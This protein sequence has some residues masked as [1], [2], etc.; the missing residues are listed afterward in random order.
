MGLDFLGSAYRGTYANE[1]GEV[2]LFILE[3][4]TSDDIQK[5]IT[6]YLDFAGEETENGPEE[7]A[8]TIEDPFNG[9]IHLHWTGNY[10][11]GF[12]GDDMAELRSGL[13]SQMKE[14]LNL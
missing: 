13:L 7:G 4:E 10:I 14:N 2:T 11:V 1:K 3:R 8:Y 12:S 5:I 6:K 9:T